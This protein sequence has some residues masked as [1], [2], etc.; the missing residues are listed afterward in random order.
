MNLKD[1]LSCPIAN[2]MKILGGK[3]KLSILY[4][5]MNGKMRFMALAKLLP[6]VSRKVLIDQLKQM[7]KDGLVVRT[8]FPESPP[9]VEY[10][11]TRQAHQLKSILEELLEW[12]K[13]LIKNR[14]QK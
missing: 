6:L 9:K 13:N 4:L 7:E 1:P 14:E 11:L 5:L 10:S 12:N 2:S 8:P 3:W